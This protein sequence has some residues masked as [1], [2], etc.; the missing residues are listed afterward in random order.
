MVGGV[1]LLAMGTVCVLNPRFGYSINNL[2]V[3]MVSSERRRRRL[4]PRHC[5]G[6]NLETNGLLHA[7]DGR[8]V[9]A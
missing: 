2:S 7:V 3:I 9:H 4:M 8:S 6:R 5:A 1:A